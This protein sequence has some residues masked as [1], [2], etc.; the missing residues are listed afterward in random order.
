[1][2]VFKQATGSTFLAY[3]THVRLANACQ[4]L[5]QMDL[6]VAEIAARVGFED[7]A[8]FDRKFRQRFQSSPRAMRI[9]LLQS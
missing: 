5:R 4:L 3:L 2:K 8:Y 6:S 9:K 7:P 1:M